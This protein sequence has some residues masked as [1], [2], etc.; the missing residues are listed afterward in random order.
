MR[1]YLLI[2]FLILSVQ[3]C[4]KADNV[5]APEDSQYGTIS[6]KIAEALG[7]SFVSKVNIKTVPSTSSV[8]SDSLGNYRLENVTPGEYTI[9]AAKAGYDSANIKVKVIAGSLTTG[10][11]FIVKTDPMNNPLAGIITGKVLN[12]NNNQPI[13]NAIISTTPY[14]S[15]ITTDQEGSFLIR[16]VTPGQYTITA[17]K[18][19]FDTAVTKITV[20][21]AQTS[22]ANLL[23]APKDTSSS[24]LYGSIQGMI[25]D[26]MTSGGV[27]GVTIITDPSTSSVFTDNNGK[28][29][30]TSISPGKY[31]LTASKTGYTSTIINVTVL[32]GKVTTAN[33]E[34]LM[35]TGKIKGKVTDSD[36]GLP[37]AGVNIKTTPGTNTVTTNSNGD[38]EISQVT[39]GTYTITAEKSGYT[40]TTVSITVKAGI[41]S[42][43]DMVMKM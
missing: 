34:L 41:I 42:N 24:A 39:A 3:A 28:Y 26:A 25:S 8:T 18:Q 11:I 32:A 7:G 16:N 12:L 10:D 27:Q 22:T 6:G 38:F 40:T 30:I 19:G 37:L 2:L 36:S 43:A 15:N 29:S 23:L 5:V 20:V 21:K 1:N 31:K 33:F 35:T 17:I 4:K 14:T 13:L 9:Y